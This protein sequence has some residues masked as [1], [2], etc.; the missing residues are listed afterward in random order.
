MRTPARSDNDLD[1]NWRAFPPESP[2]DL[3]ILI[4][5]HGNS[6]FSSEKLISYE[7][8]YRT[9]PTKRLSLDIAAFYNDY[10][11]LQAI[12]L[13]NDLATVEDSWLHIPA[14]FVNGAKGQT[15]GFEAAAN[16]QAMEGWRLQLAYS[17]L[18]M[19]NK[20][21]SPD[22]TMV[23]D[24]TTAPRHQISLFSGFSISRTIELD[25]WLHYTD[26]TSFHDFRESF[27]R[28]LSLNARLG[29]HPRKDLELSLTGTNLS[30]P[31]HVEFAQ[32]VY[33]FLEQ[34]ERSIYGQ[35]KWSF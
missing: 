29:W 2:I 34:V 13:R 4:S 22:L 21:S 16:W 7:V 20:P 19:Q 31:S 11:D 9:W 3:P 28:Y 18:R 5:L 30:G 14:V 1:L 17:Y 24:D 33:P 6:A 8:G 10:D 12:A 25:L 15:Y 26:A 35:L 23:F 32:E 27:D